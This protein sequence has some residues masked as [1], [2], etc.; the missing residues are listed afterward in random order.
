MPIK[1][2]DGTGSGK[3]VRIG[4]RE[5][6]P[7]ENE[8]VC[9][10]DMHKSM[11][12]A[13]VLGSPNDPNHYEIREFGTFLA[14]ITSLGEWLASCKVELVAMEST[15]V[16]WMPTHAK[17]VEMGFTVLVIN[18]AHFKILK[19]RKT[20]VEDAYFLATRARAGMLHGSR[21][22]PREDSE[23]REI[24]RSR[25][26]LVQMST[27]MKNRI[28]KLL[29][30]SGFKLG[31]VMSDVL[32]KTGRIIIGG[33]LTRTPPVDIVTVI[34]K[35]MGY[36]LKTPRQRLIDAM[37]VPMTDDLQFSLE[38]AFGTFN[39]L[40]RR[41]ADC[42]ARL[43]VRIEERGETHNIELLETLPGVSTVAAMTLLAE[44]GD[45]SSFK[46]PRDLASWA[47]MCP[48]NNESAG[49]RG[50]T[51]TRKGNK[52]LGRILCEIALSAT[53]CECY[54]KARYAILKAARGHKRAVTAIGHK[55][56]KIVYRMLTRNEPYEDHLVDYEAMITQRNAPRWIRC[57]AKYKG[58]QVSK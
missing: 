42:E 28:H 51:T 8:I 47:G 54:F 5:P 31:D 24:S 55:L 9:G 36:K 22:M 26:K 50:A 43:A 40:R 18:A 25:V 23:V 13:C 12:M 34:E 33:L 57:L 21:I 37:S 58:L 11:A 1:T 30:K 4:S 29:D 48:G 41:I 3:I 32:G 39:D 20:D 35:R 14:D 2:P 15:G 44:L 10:I 38:N 27:S 16:Y 19:G 56:L 46:S 7:S 6:F 17:L 52:Q 45:L 53:R 49:K